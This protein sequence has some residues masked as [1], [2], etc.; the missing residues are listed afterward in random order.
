[1][2]TADLMMGL[3]KNHGFT[4]TGTL[5]VKVLYSDTPKKRMPVMYEPNIVIIGQ[6]TKVGYLGSERFVYDIDNYL[7]LTIPMPF[8]CETFASPKDPLLAMYVPVDQTVLAELVMQMTPP[9]AEACAKKSICSCPMDDAMRESS[10]RL[11]RALYSEDECA[12]LGQGLVREVVFR[13]LCGRHAPSL[14]ALAQYNSRYGRITAALKKI[15]SQ[16]G[17]DITVETLARE[18]G[19][20]VS[21][22]HR[23]FKEMTLDS[24]VQYLKKIR[25]NKAKVLI[26]GKGESVSSAAMEVGYESVSQF[27]REY[28]R[29]FGHNPSERV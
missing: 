23:T 14:F 22:F 17:S 29:Y 21:L 26:N 19:M 3:V 2:T 13:A 27:S 4:D 10:D 8:E 6:G 18:S 28:K 1:M 7:V 20:S 5:G 12:I 11:L 25:L 24:P 15:H 9:K 16:F